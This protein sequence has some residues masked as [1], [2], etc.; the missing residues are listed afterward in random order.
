MYFI[1]LL[2]H[3]PYQRLRAYLSIKYDLEKCYSH[4]VNEFQLCIV[5][6]SCYLY[7]KIHLVM[8]GQQ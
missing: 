6:Y 1:R 4:I 7:L 3:K 8:Y 2:L 5:C